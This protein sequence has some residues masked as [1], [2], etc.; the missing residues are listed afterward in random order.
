MR[1][2]NGEAVLPTMAGQRFSLREFLDHERH[3]GPLLVIPSILILA[4]FV[5]YPF[6]LGIW[7]SMTNKM[8]GH[9]PRFV[10]LANFQHLLS[11]TIFI[12]TVR[13]T[14]IYT[15]VT[16][17]FKMVLGMALAL[18][19][20]QQFPLRNLVRAM[21]LLPWIIPTAL[22][23]LAWLW[24]LNPTFGMLNWCIVHLGGPKVNWLGDTTM[25]MVSIITV[26]IWRGVP[27]FGICLLA[28]LQTIPQE[29]HEAA[30][31]DG[32]GTARRFWNV[33]VPLLQPVLLLVALFTTIWTIADFQLVYVLTRGGPTNSTHIFGT[34]AYQVALDAGRLGEGAAISLYMFPF[35]LVSIAVVLAR[36]RRD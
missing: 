36:I 18:L 25:A 6:L 24:I 10:G 4:V 21:L 11:N 27:F 28:A 26:N 33:T 15:V 19:I 17:F 13:N 29:L 2:T 12:Q 32:A 20:N 14:L 16:V 22:S 35:L 23:T 34:Y 7:F 1:S 31:I 8:V 5:A 30:S 9:E 3:L